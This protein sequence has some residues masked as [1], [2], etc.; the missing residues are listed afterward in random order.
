LIDCS[1]GL[2]RAVV[3]QLIE[4]PDHDGEA[5]A[6]KK[7]R[8]ENIVTVSAMQRGGRMIDLV[9]SIKCLQNLP[10][11]CLISPSVVIKKNLHS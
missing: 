10:F 5:P 2:G 6:F 3:R 11:N 1:L 7:M 4:A 9:E 8:D